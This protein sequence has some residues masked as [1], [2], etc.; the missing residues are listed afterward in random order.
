[1]PS[2]AE[3]LTGLKRTTEAV[4]FHRKVKGVGERSVQQGSGNR[5][6]PWSVRK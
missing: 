1:M 2:R 6:E 3:N 4:T 5:E